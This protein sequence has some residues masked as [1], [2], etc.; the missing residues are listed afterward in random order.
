M[1]Q[2]TFQIYIAFLLKCSY[3]YDFK[4]FLKNRSII[5]V[6]L[7]F[8]LPYFLLSPFAVTLSYAC[9]F[10]LSLSP[11]PFLFC[12]SVIGT[13]PSSQPSGELLVC[14]NSMAFWEWDQGP[15]PPARL[16]KKSF[17]ECCLVCSLPERA[18]QMF[19]NLVFGVP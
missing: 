13:S 18:L 8:V 6:V 19:L 11:H 5:C 1:K 12:F 2:K 15:P 9:M 10:C 17:S 16:P 3:V 14:Q 7:F 4:H